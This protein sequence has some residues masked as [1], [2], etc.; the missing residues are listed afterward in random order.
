METNL[1]E[2]QVLRRQSLEQLRAMG[3]DPYPAALY[4]VNCLAADIRSHYTESS[5][6][7]KWKEVVLAGRLMTRRIMGKAAFA[8][9]QD[10]SGRMQIYVN[11]DEICPDENKDLYNTVFK[12]LLDIGD[13]IGVKGHVFTTQTGELSVHVTELMLLSKCLNPLPLPKQD[14]D[15]NV[16]DAFT[17]PEARYRMRYVDLV[18]NPQIRE[19]FIKRTK[20]IQ[21]LR[22]TFNEQGYLEVETPI[23]QTVHGGATARP[24]MT[25][26]N[27][28]DIPFTCASQ[29][30]YTSSV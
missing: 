4:P 28:L 26:H 20:V 19:T 30:S 27:A 17:D 2:Q 12:K 5:E 1:N 16:Y 7:Q 11:R 10:S 15:G 3:I 13:I 25:H 8:D 14:A 22:N 6:D 29:T 9:L 21:S 23:L 18:V 24:F